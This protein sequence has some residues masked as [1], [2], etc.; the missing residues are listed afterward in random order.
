MSR[1]GDSS[2]YERD[3][4]PP[5]DGVALHSETCA[6]TSPKWREAT[7]GDEEKTGGVAWQRAVRRSLS[8]LGVG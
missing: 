2:G 6:G 4:A 5:G 1:I 7:A 8:A 3:A